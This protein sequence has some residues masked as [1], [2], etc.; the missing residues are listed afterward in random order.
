MEG[1]KLN[2]FMIILLLNFYFKI[3][4]LIYKSI[5]RVLTKKSLNL[6]PFLPIPPNFGSNENLRF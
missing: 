4:S 6:I 2:H 3:K 1:M 5:L